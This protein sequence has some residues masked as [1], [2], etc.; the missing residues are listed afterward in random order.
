MAIPKRLVIAR[1]ASYPTVSMRREATTYAPDKMHPTNI[2]PRVL[3]KCVGS[4]GTDIVNKSS[5]AE[6]VEMCG[7]DCFLR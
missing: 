1:K 3:S 2:A 6:K 4:P 5:L 7:E